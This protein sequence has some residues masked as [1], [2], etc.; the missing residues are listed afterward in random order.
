MKLFALL[1]IPFFLISCTIHNPQPRSVVSP[2]QQAFS[3]AFSEF[4]GSHRIAG[5]QKLVVDFP[6]SVWAGR[7][8]TIILYAQELD[9]RKAQNEQ[10]QKSEQHQTLEVKRLRQ[11]NQKLK[12][13]N[14]QLDK[15]NRQ[16][17][18]KIEQLTSLL[19]QSEKYPQ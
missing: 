4:Q 9:Q 15:L 19:I 1:L 13:R 14:E 16:L 12:D 6:S 17:M 11:Q 7:A 2:D 5:F 18:D 3:Q 10:L 8:E